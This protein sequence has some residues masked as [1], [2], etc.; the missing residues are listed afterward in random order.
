MN[1]YFFFKKHRIFNQTIFNN[2]VTGSY[3]IT[4]PTGGDV[5]T[6]SN[7]T[8]SLLSSIDGDLIITPSSLNGD[9]SFSPP[10]ITLNNLNT[11]EEFTYTPSLWG[12]RSI[13][14]SNDRGLSD[15]PQHNFVSRIQVGSVGYPINTGSISINMG[16]FSMVNAS[17]LWL[18]EFGRIISGEPKSP[19]SD[20]IINKLTE[21]SHKL[22]VDVGAS[23]KGANSSYTN[24][25]SVVSGNTEFRK[26]TTTTYPTDFNPT[27][28]PFIEG[29]A[30]QGWPPTFR[31]PSGLYYGYVHVTGRGDLTIFQPGD[32]VMFFCNGF[33]YPI[34]ADPNVYTVQS[35]ISDNVLV[36]DS[37]YIGPNHNY[38]IM[39]GYY[40]RNPDYTISLPTDAH[41]LVYHR[42][43]DTGGADLYET[44]NTKQSGVQLVTSSSAYYLYDDDQ[45]PRNNE[46]GVT[47]AGIP[48]APLILNYDEAVNDRINHCLAITLT[49]YGGVMQHSCVWPGLA[50]AAGVDRTGVP[51]G[52]R[53]RLRKDWYDANYS[54]FSQINRN[55]LKAIRDYGLIVADGGTMLQIW[56]AGDDRWS[57]SDI[58]ALESIPASALEVPLSATAPQWS[59]TGPESGACFALAGPWE[60][61]YLI[62]DNKNTPAS[63][64]YLR[65][66]LNPS[67]AGYTNTGPVFEQEASGHGPYSFN[68][69]PTQTGLYYLQL[70]AFNQNAY[71]NPPPSVS[72]TSL[73]QF[74]FLSY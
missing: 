45:S 14:Y 53:F 29:M 5:D 2:S 55:I 11:S 69:T 70:T 34:F 31:L 51:Y 40:N 36:L 66:S 73:A 49:N 39:Q 32:T 64:W 44:Y 12:I 68:W 9:G 23:W 52:G 59:I 71:W 7:F 65:S 41:L 63:N 1:L 8:A 20:G 72:G 24:P 16:G 28:I 54:S 6:Q 18:R 17:S 47:A 35:V 61:N 50:I 15:P 42:N 4:Y 74:T 57:I 22:V 13:S 48:M 62:A 43:E 60:W 46:G 25:F 19:Y 67:M 38:P 3:S 27:G 56:T 37:P 33:G 30:Q 26:L 10:N 58:A 21:G